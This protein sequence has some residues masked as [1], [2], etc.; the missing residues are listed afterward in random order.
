MPRTSGVGVAVR[1]RNQ[2]HSP[3][4]FGTLRTCKTWRLVD[5]QNGQISLSVSRC[6]NF[7]VFISV[8]I[9][10][11]KPAV[12]TKASA[13]HVLLMYR[14]SPEVTPPSVLKFD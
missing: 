2:N 10:R 13:L 8:E 7:H 6:F 5:F 11:L 9:H 3:K 14:A 4:P 12:N 1:F